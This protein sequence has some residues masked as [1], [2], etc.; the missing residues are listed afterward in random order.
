MEDDDRESYEARKAWVE[1]IGDAID[2]LTGRVAALDVAQKTIFSSLLY[3]VPHLI[4]IAEGH[5]A[6]YG[7]DAQVKLSTA[8]ETKAFN[9]A[10]AELRE[11]VASC[12]EIM[13]PLRGQ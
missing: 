2:T 12:K 1:A 8:V 6:G 11:L 10:L 3:E 13:A 9:E 4:E 7:D 5:L